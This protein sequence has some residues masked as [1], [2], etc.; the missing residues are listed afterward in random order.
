MI[1][2]SVTGHEFITLDGVIDNPAWSFDYP[3]DPKMGT[4]IAEIMGACLLRFFLAR[5]CFSTIVPR[6]ARGSVRSFV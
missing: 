3:P 2:G 1:M 4:A 5:R 6:L